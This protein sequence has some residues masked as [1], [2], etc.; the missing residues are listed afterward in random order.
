MAHLSMIKTD[1][2]HSSSRS[3]FVKRLTI[4]CLG[5]IGWYDRHL[6]RLDLS[7]LDDHLLRDIG[8]TPE[9]VRREC[10]KPFWR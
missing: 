6:Q 1:L 3:G 8:L 4:T 2:Q 7:S 5:L 10:A 9:Q